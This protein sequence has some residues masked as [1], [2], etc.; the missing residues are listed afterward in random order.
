MRRAR[1]LA[2]DVVS[3]AREECKI[4]FLRRNFTHG[5]R[6]AIPSTSNLVSGSH[7]H[8]QDSV[9]RSIP[10]HDAARRA[11]GAPVS[12]HAPVL[13]PNDVSNI[14]AK[15][16]D[17]RTSSNRDA[18]PGSDSTTSCDATKPS[19]DLGHHETARRNRR[20]LQ[21][22]CH[23]RPLQQVRC[24]METFTQ[25]IR[26]ARR[27]VRQGN[28]SR[29]RRRSGWLDHSRRSWRGDDIAPPLAVPCGHEHRAV[30]LAATHEQ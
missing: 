2:C 12:R 9:Q 24:W 10:R 29:A 13:G 11:R 8:S 23:H 22:L 30:A 25:R 15:K 19:L 3:K 28:H 20:L 5:C 6:K 4:C 21:P 26:R 1:S 27:D 17:S 7:A 16:G 14:G 18:S